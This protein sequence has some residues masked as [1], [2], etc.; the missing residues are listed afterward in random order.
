M[1]NLKLKILGVLALS[2]VTALCGCTWVASKRPSTTETIYVNGRIFT[3]NGK[4]PW[5]SAVAVEKGIF[6]YVGTTE[7]ALALK[8]SGAKVVDLK[9]KTLVPGLYDSHIHPIAAGEEL[10]FKCNF[11]QTASVEEI[12]LTVKAY[13]KTAEPG[14]WITGGRWAPAHLHN[15]DKAKLD[16]V[17]N[18]HPVVLHDF[19]NHNIWANSAA[20]NAAG[21]TKEMAAAYGELIQRNAKGDM[22]GVFVEK[23]TELVVSKIPTRS[24][25]ELDQALLRALKEVNRYGII[26]IKDSYARS[27]ELTAYNRLDANGG[28]TAHVAAALSWDHGPG[29][30]NLEE[31]KA[32]I[33]KIRGLTSPHVRTDFAKISLDGIPPT[34][35]AAMLAP[36]YPE[37]EGNI[38]SLTMTEDAF[39]RDVVWLDSMGLTVKV[40]AVGDRAARI[41]L[42]AFEAA[43]KVNGIS[44]RRHEVAHACLIAP[45][46]IK[47]F[48]QLDV[49][50]DL[51]PAFWYPG[52][53][54]DGLAALVGKERVASYC[55]VADFLTAGASPTYGTDWPVAPTVNPWV[56]LEALVTREN[57]HGKAPGR[58]AAPGQKISIEKAL[59]LATIN[60]AKAQGIEAKS[61]SIEVGKTADFLVLNQDI[62]TID[63][64][65]IGDTIV[66][67]TV[68]EGKVVYQ[69]P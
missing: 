22:T 24:E 49:V 40:H 63:P 20:I 50:P 54:F 52:A 53:V 64:R 16:E 46:D 67:T 6:T 56:A 28:L 38:G 65:Q 47:R 1:N 44:G 17:S 51:S 39:I 69:R 29:G 12:L 5:A 25:K 32:R 23:A 33:L 48:G 4:A 27:P 58:T 57:P 59:S 7:A 30:E 37:E 19:S 45:E 62:F 34:K 26:G 60:G 61:G 35:T 21:I 15:L 41:C 2:L 13:A 8:G 3:G 42:D 55:P 43:Q 18:G 9:G 68:F 11:P 66:L 10:L 14:A 31:R 36:Y